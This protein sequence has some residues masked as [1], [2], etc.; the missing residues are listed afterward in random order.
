MSPTHSHPHSPALSPHLKSV[1]SNQL[2]GAGTQGTGTGPGASAGALC[3]DKCDGKHATDKCPHFK[4]AREDHP[5]AKK[6]GWAKFGKPSTLPG[7]VLRSAKVVRQPGDG[8]CL[9]HSMSYGLGGGNNAR[10]LRGEICHYLVQNPSERI[11][12]T[13][14]SEWI[15][16]DS[17]CSVK[18]YAK[19][20]SRG[21]WGGGIEMAAFQR[22]KGCNVH[23]YERV[24]GSFKRISAF[25]CDN[26][27][28]TRPVVRVLYQG[29]V[30]YDALVA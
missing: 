7:A 10:A 25:D 9:F 5:D 15:K 29:G 11:S 24:G 28:E 14:L 8:N 2:L 16:W 17:R 13:P 21:A 18:D 1:S 23:V 19:R 20:M 26:K 6:N 12:D 4:K 27:P 30:H 22:I 3:C